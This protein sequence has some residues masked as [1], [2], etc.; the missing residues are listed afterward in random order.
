MYEYL[1][2]GVIMAFNFIILKVK[3]ERGRYL[4]LSVD[5]AVLILLFYFAGSTVGGLFAAA[6]TGAIVSL[7]L[8]F[9]PPRLG[10]A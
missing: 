10:T 5:V 3:A 2:I 8:L 4:D 9:N 6:I 7:F 1:F